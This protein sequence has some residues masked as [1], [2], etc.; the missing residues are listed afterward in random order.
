MTS[1]TQGTTPITGVYVGG[2]LAVAMYLGMQQLWHAPT[3]APSPTVLGP[4][5]STATGY[6]ALSVVVPD[7]QAG[8]NLVV[9]A[10]S[11][12]GGSVTSSTASDSAGNAYTALPAPTVVIGTGARAFIAKA[13]SA[14]ASL[15]VT[16]AQAPTPSNRQLV[17]Y[18]VRGGTLTNDAANNQL[19]LS[20]ASG[21]APFAPSG[22]AIGGAGVAFAI[23]QYTSNSST[24]A[25]VTVSGMALDLGGTAKGYGNQ[26]AAHATFSAAQSNVPVSFGT[27]VSVPAAWSAAWYPMMVA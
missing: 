18:V 10:I 13:S 6:G 27:T 22:L 26:F 8:D 16:V 24:A 5:I 17:A 7:V 3:S 2:K 23:G 12:T 15:A 19:G 25:A 1:V 20:Q 9:F 11:S 4:Y 14:A 21:T